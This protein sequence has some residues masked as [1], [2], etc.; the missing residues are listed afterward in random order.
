MWYSDIQEKW[1]SSVQQIKNR[2]VHAQFL[3]QNPSQDEQTWIHQARWHQW[4]IS[5]RMRLPKTDPTF[6]H[7]LT[8]K[9]WQWEQCTFYCQSI[10]PHVGLHG[11][12]AGK[13]KGNFTTDDFTGSQ[14]SREHAH[15]ELLR[16]DNNVKFNSRR[17]NCLRSSAQTEPLQVTA[18]NYCFHWAPLPSTLYPWQ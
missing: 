7:R 14:E 17:M 15:C 8:N 5:A 10:N 16:E 9:P 11:G 3:A 4:W 1:L 13:K 18:G 6:D 2:S 12:K